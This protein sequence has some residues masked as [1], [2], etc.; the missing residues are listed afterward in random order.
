MEGLDY[1]AL[2]LYAD[3]C[4]HRMR[5]AQ[6]YQRDLTMRLILL[7]LLIASTLQPLAGANAAP[8]RP[9]YVQVRESKLRLEPQFWSPTVRVLT[10][11]DALESMGPVPG[12]KSWIKAKAGASEGYVHVSAVTSRRVVFNAST[13]ADMVRGAS[14]DV[15]LAGK[16]FNKQVETHYGT[17][18]GLDFEVVNEVEKI[19]VD[20]VEQAA[21][22]R[23]G[24]LIEHRS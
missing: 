4:I 12:N 17:S 20:P 22:I 10:Y 8:S 19:K 2:I 15:V 1:K 21:F 13:K 24:G 3:P 16:G 14:G 7:A 5:V 6:T 9:V 11:G 23:D 18:K